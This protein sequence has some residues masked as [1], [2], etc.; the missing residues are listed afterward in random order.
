MKNE[1]DLHEAKKNKPNMIRLIL[2]LTILFG[3]IMLLGSCASSY[4]TEPYKIKPGQS[5][6]EAYQKHWNKHLK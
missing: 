2:L 3:L 1:Q 4:R 5:P 6:A